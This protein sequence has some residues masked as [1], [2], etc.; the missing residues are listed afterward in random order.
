M[1]ITGTI[2]KALPIATGTT[3]KGGTWAVQQYILET[4][5]EKPQS[6]LLEAFGQD[7]INSFSLKENE[8]VTVEYET[9]VNEYKDRYYGKNRILSVTRD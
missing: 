7:N 1:Q 3:K 4:S 9:E 2:K 6:I 8:I 5:D